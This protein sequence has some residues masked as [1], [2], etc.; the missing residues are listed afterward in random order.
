MR[1]NLND[2][3]H[4]RNLNG[5]I[6]LFIFIVCLSSYGWEDNCSKPKVAVKLSAIVLEDEFFKYLNTQYPEQP[7]ASWLYQFQEKVLEELRMNSPETEF[8]S[9]NGALPSD[10]TYIFGYKLIL[11]AAG[12]DIKIAGVVLS[13][14]TAYWVNCYL[15][16]NDA[17]G[18]HN[19]TFVSFSSI[20]EDINRAIERN[21]A[22]F[23]NIGSRIQAFE[24]KHPV[25]PRGPEMTVSPN[26]KYVSPLK[27]E[28]KLDL[29]IKVRNCH[30]EDVY[31]KNHGQKVFLPK[32]TERG[33]INRTE[34]FA[35]GVW[36]FSNL[37]ILS[38][39]QQAGAS[40]T[41][42]LKRGLSASQE[43]IN[44]LTCGRDKKIV[45]EQKVEIRGLEITVTPQRRTVEPDQETTVDVRFSRVDVRGGKEPI[46]GKKIAINVKG[47]KDGRVSPTGEVSTDA[48]G[49]ARLTYHAGERDKKVTFSASYQPQ[50]YDGSVSG[51]AEVNIVGEHEWFGTLTIEQARRFNCGLEEEDE[52]GSQQLNESE[53]LVQRATIHLTSDDFDLARVPA[54]GAFPQPIEASGTITATFTHERTFSGQAKSTECVSKGEHKMVS[55]GNWMREYQTTTGEANHPVRNE[56]I[57]ILFARESAADKAGVEDIRNRMKELAQQAKEA[58]EAMDMDRVKELQGEIAKLQQG[59]GG[60]S[61]RLRIRVFLNYPSR[62]AVMVNTE[63]KDYNVCL[64]RLTKDDSQDDSKEIQL[65]LPMV[66]ELK[67]TYTKGK[68]GSDR[69]V[70]HMED[71]DH[72]PSGRSG[73]GKQK[74]PDTEYRVTAELKLERRR[75]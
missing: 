7:R 17:C 31:D 36:P 16:S 41:Y 27:E 19:T 70:A 43:S 11:T 39:M 45:K 54:V 64:G 5:F 30:G 8:V 18:L 63:R 69:V 22:L 33:E 48:G 10:C 72:K 46:A 6:F 21:I 44:I 40:A 59:G 56:H 58:A 9:V 60:D 25:P 71:T 15:K 2:I 68:D 13:E 49:I 61:I 65:I 62:D 47:L 38:I 67:G 51:K 20:D 28:R 26:R 73:L 23:G 75:K 1:S 24:D 66:V 74:C 29:Q 34:N 53:E 3:K 37:L 32:K 35:Q 50:G 52:N 12:E 55:P 57:R 42:T 4:I 14:Y